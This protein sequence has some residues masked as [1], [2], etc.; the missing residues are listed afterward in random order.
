MATTELGRRAF[1]QAA[2]ATTGGVL[3]S[4]SLETLLAGAGRRHAGRRAARARRRPPRRQG[5][6]AP[7]AGVPLPV[8]PRH[9]RARPARPPITLDDGTVLPGRHD[10][11]AAFPAAD[12]NVWLVRNHEVN[13]PG[14]R[15]RS[16]PAIALRP[17]RGGGTT[18]IHVT[19]RRHVLDAFTSLNGTQMNCSGG[20]DAVGQLD[21]LRGDRERARRRPDF[22]G[23]SNA[24]LEQRHGFLFEVPAGRPVGPRADHRR[25]SL[26]PRG[27]RLQPARGRS[28]T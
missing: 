20:R 10:G 24:T 25:G 28:C 8:V 3:V 11:M 5:A 6:A 12:G 13:G 22:T 1:L 9:R 15:R 4:G 23:A 21:H 26:R 14:G 18:T 19:P 17:P 27:G 16:V 2:M 7:A